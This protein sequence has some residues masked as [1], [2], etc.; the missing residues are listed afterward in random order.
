M[1]TRPVIAGR[2]TKKGHHST[3]VCMSITKKI[4]AIAYQKAVLCG[5]TGK[6]SFSGFIEAFMMLLLSSII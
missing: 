3:F 2:W 1:A 4:N 6:S 5:C